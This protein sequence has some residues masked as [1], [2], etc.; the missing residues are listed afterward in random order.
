MSD[1]LLITLENERRY[2]AKELHDGVAQTAL[3]L[4]LQAGICRK[5]LERGNLEMLVNE[6][7]QLEERV[8]LASAQIRDMI[9]DMRPPQAEP[10]AELDDYIEQAINAHLER[11]GPPVA[12]QSQ[13]S[14]RLPSLS[15][16]QMLALHRMI[17]E[18][19]LNVRKYAEAK[20]AHL[21]LS[22]DDNNFYIT[23]S[24]DGKGF[25]LP[26]VQARP[27]DKGGAGLAS[28]YARA[29]AIGGSLTIARETTEDRTQITI[30]LPKEPEQPP[31]VILSARLP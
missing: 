22:D 1:T 7:T 21:T 23:I 30:T 16:P 29:Q 28:L 6:L 14:D 24:D 4:G 12:Y 8:Q 15:A 10:N 26:E 2:V 3:Q 19:L 13:L 5:L 27:I 11:S 20:N 31:D 25:D 18:A 17:Q 9:A